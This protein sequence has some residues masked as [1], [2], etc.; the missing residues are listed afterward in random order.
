MG[1][2]ERKRPTERG[3][4]KGRTI[5]KWMLKKYDALIWTGFI[6]LWIEGCYQ[7]GD[8]HQ[9]YIKFGDFV[10]LSKDSYILKKLSA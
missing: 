7:Q 2:C 4:H 3:G 5:I 10:D 6:R 8:E 1:K 9:V